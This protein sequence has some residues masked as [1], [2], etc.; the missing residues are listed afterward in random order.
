MSDLSN[1]TP[2]GTYRLQLGR[3]GFGFA[4]AGEL[5]PYL[6]SLGVS[7]VYLPPILQAAPGSTHGYDVTDHSRISA[8]LGGEDGFRAMVASFH[9]VGLRVLLDI[10]P[11]HMAV[12]SPT[13][14][15]PAVDSVV[16]EGP[17][18]PYARWFDVD[19]AAGDGKLVLPGE[20]TPNYR[21][22]FDISGL[23]G[24]RQ[25]DRTVF[26]QT[27]ELVLRLVSEGLVNGLRI[28]HPDGLA[29][30]RGYLDEL[31]MGSGGV[32]TVVEKITTG[33]ETLPVDWHCAGTTGYDSLGMVGGLF[34]DPEGEKPLTETYLSFTG[35]VVDF[36]GVEYAARRYVLDQ[37]LRPE[38]ERLQ[39]VLARAM[40]DRRP[41]RLENALTELLAAMPVYRT[42]VVP[43][44][45]A[46]PEAVAV[47]EDAARWAR[48]RLPAETHDD[49]DAVVALALG[50]GDPPSP[51][52]VVRFQQTS[53]PVAARGVEDTAFYRWSRLISLNEVGG[54]PG[55]L[56]VS[57]DRFH[58]HCVRLA[59]DWPGTMTT[60]STHDTKRGED[61][62]AR[63]A[64]LAEMPGPWT[65]AVNRWHYRAAPPGLPGAAR[66]PI[67][68]DLE[69][70]LWQTLAGAWPVTGERLS[71]FLSKAM[72]EAKTS[73]SW[74]DCDPVYEEAVLGYARRILA[75]DELITDLTGFVSLLE[76]YARVN[77][78]G[79]KLVQLTMPGVPDVYQGCELTGLSLVD[80][81]NRRPVDYEQRRAR[82]ARMDDGG[83]PQDL[84]DEKLLVTARVLRLLRAWPDVSAAAYRPVRASGHAA[85]HVVAFGRG[86]RL[87]AVATRLP[88]GLERR[89]GWRD[90]RM[91]VG[92]GA[93]RDVLTGRL[94]QG[95]RL[96]LG[97]VLGSLPVALLQLDNG[98]DGSS[99]E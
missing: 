76:P 10:V 60:L 8:E 55:H 52:F 47:L 71:E 27:H 81:D 13:S 12:P 86:P 57:P 58:A 91:E 32:W 82:L 31:A 53:A 4:E 28:D 19:W 22:F 45:D 16:R 84:D 50:R 70:M 3:D 24:L 78:L 87:V 63:L 46:P 15:S 93:W 37:G 48:S 94:W 11:N 41:E 5:A 88:V 92:G 36:A 90:T 43:G 49:L 17:A 75:D 62:R 35:G 83:A 98:S 44:E 80:P 66:P 6:A 67:E 72:R 96:R 68:P 14:L 7:H 99:R 30:P 1:A 79:Q 29:D 26:E 9:A 74:A 95:S 20:G 65:R 64:V 89:G 25:E 40:P 34:V 18:S 73:T 39:D 51:E 38:L 56:A 59:R 69:Y 85:E 54:D 2:T 21:R 77:S 61:V 23:I 42:Y 33:A 97:D